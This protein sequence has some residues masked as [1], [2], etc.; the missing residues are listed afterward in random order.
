MANT[1]IKDIS[2]TATSTNA[3]DVCVIDG[4]TAGT[5]KIAAGPLG[6]VF[7][8]HLKVFHDGSNGYVENGTGNLSLKNASAEYIKMLIATGGVELYHNGTKQCETSA[9]GLSFPDGKGID[10]SNS[11]TSAGGGTGTTGTPASSVF[12][13]YEY[14]SWT[15]SFATTGTNFSTMI[16][17]V[18]SAS[19]VKFGRQVICQT[20]I[21]TTSVDASG[22]SGDVVIGG[23]PFIADST[24]DSHGTAT[25]GQANSWVNMPTS[26]FTVTDA[27]QVRLMRSG[28]AG[29]TTSL[30]A[31][32]FTAGAT[33]YQNAV[34]I[35]ISYISKT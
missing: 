17:D 23:L 26:G 16:T 24:T 34:M 32:D 30:V 33:P 20:M 11:T 14:G 13:D 31:S 21:R 1:R 6:G 15:P 10:F 18:V 28:G 35:S 19:Y 5:R 25:V 9:T 8:Q 2:T 3:D 22:A 7:N 12:S 29:F 27:A 4:A